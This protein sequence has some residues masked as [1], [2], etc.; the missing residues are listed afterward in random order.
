MIPK[1]PLTNRQALPGGLG[2]SR[3]GDVVRTDVN[4]LEQRRGVA[5]KVANASRF[6]LGEL[7][8]VIVIACVNPSE[9]FEHASGPRW[10]VSRR[11]GG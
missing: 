11:L 2:F 5:V 9:K 3:T 7:A 6:M 8:G 10:S 1:R 4:T